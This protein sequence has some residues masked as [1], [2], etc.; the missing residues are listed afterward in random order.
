MIDIGTINGMATPPKSIL[1]LVIYYKNI[2]HHIKEEGQ[3]DITIGGT[4]MEINMQ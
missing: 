2:I 1:S 3:L 4:R